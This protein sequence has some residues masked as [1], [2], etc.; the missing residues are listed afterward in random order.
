MAGHLNART[1]DIQR[2]LHEEIAGV[3]LRLTNRINDVDR[4]LHSV[5]IALTNKMAD[6][7]DV[8]V[9]W[10]VASVVLQAGLMIV[11]A[12]LSKRLF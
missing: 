12:W 6:W 2:R 9:R 10:I 11:V 8:I 1:S 4:R 5:E 3:E 7:R